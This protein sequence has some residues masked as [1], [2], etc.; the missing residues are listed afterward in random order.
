[1][2]RG[3]AGSY[4]IRR[5]GGELVKAFVPLPLPPKPPLREVPSLRE[6]MDQALV[7]LGRLDSVGTLLPDASLFL[8]TY[9]RKE[10]VLSSQIEGTQSSLSD[11]L[12]YELEQAPGVPMGDAAEVSCAVAAIEHGLRRVRS[13]FPITGRLLREV[14]GKMLSRGRGKNK[15]PGEFRRSQNWIGGTRP[16]NAHFVPPPHGRVPECMAALER[17]LHDMPLRTAPL[18]KA[19]MAHVQFETIHPFLDGNGRVGRSL[20]TLILCAEGVLRAPL[21]YVSLF[22]KQHRKEYYALLDRVRIEGDW[23]RW[24]VFFATAVAEAAGSAVETARAL[25]GL[26]VRDRERIGLLGRVAGSALRVHHEMQR[27][28]LATIP[29]LEKMT[30]LTAPAVTKALVAMERAAIVRETTGRRRNRVYAYSAHLKLL[31]A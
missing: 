7:A 12:L 3:M 21:L 16:G 17:F 5:L 11:L 2:K 19:G 22:L 15:A 6:A 18:L 28:P 1:M 13:G 23:E 20:I 26:F 8:Y 10:A 30:G 14:H 4:D 31:N 24:M 29:A 27:R 25:N 9:V